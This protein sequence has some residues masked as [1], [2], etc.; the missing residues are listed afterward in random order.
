MEENNIHLKYES[1]YLL[2][3]YNEYKTI[4][5]NRN[6]NKIKKIEK[7]YED[8]YYK[9]DTTIN[10]E[11][12]VDY[13]MINIFDIEF[14]YIDNDISFFDKY[15]I[16]YIN[17]ILNSHNIKC[18]NIQ[19]D[20]KYSLYVSKEDEYFSR[21]ILLDKNIFNSTFIKEVKLEEVCI[22]EIVLDLNIFGKC[23]DYFIISENELVTEMIKHNLEL[24]ITRD[25]SDY[26]LINENIK[27]YC[28]ECDINLKTYVI[29]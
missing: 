11:T 21:S 23:E 25:D 5:H 7:K 12:D 26:F 16:K 1:L 22:R 4:I 10:M 17:H 2:P 19:K 27:E 6:E 15:M 29:V 13:N 8:M 28:N 3:N 24:F 9:I 14:T 20:G 18:F